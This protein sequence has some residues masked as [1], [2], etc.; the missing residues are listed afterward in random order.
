[1][2]VRLL[3]VLGILSVLRCPRQSN[4][5]GP[6]SHQAFARIFSARQLFWRLID[7]VRQYRERNTLTRT[8][9]AGKK[10][11][12]I[13]H[14][15]LRR[16]G[17]QVVARRFRLADG[18]G[19]IDIIARDGDVLVFVEVKA[20]GNADYGGPERAVDPEKQRKILRTART[21]AL[22]SNADWSLVRFDIITVVLARPTVVNH[23]KDAFYP[24]RR[25]R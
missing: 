25:S 10:G 13:A 17:L 12:D 22:K 23:Y 7:A 4:R 2:H 6:R 19:E 21:Y 9:A 5:A 18:S 15:Y 3:A 16:Q 11:E 8:Q 20:R 14:R 1:M 24:A